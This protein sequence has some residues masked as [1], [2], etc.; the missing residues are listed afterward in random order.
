M[1]LIYVGKTAPNRK[2]A[3]LHRHPQW[4]LIYHLSGEGTMQVGDEHHTFAPGQILICPPGMYHDKVSENGFVDLYCRFEGFEFPQAAYFLEDSY[5]RR[6]QQMMQLLYTLY[7][8]ESVPSVCSTLA[9]AILGLVR[10]MLSGTEENQYVKMLRNR[11]AEGFS[12]PYFSLKDAMAAIPLNA[13]H[14]RRLFVKELGQT[15]HNYLALLRLEKAKRLLSEEYGSVAEV[16]YRCGYYDALYFSKC[17]R[18]ATGLPPSQ[19]R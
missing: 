2:T 11:I 13:D 3:K 5:D 10:P 19:W 16:A 8:E 18:A 17:F 9:D 12:D 7:Y 6:I 4:E 1:N 14:L 15:P